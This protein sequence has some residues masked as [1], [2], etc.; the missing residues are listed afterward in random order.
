MRN[1]WKKDCAGLGVIVFAGAA[2]AAA[3]IPTGDPWLAGFG[4]EGLMTAVMFLPCL[5]WK[6]AHRDEG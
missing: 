1:T 4:V 3:L 6:L 2:V 5:G